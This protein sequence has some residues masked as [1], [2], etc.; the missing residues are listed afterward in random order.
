YV[1]FGIA[2]SW[3]TILGTMVLYLIT[4][5]VGVW[6]LNKPISWGFDITNFVFWVGIGHAGT[7]ISAILYL[8]RQKWRTGINRFADPMTSFTVIFA[9]LISVIHVSRIWVEYLIAPRPNQ[10]NMWPNCRR[11]LLWDFF[12]VG[13]YFT[14]SLCFWYM[15]MIP[16]IATLRDRAKGTIRQIA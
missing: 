13:T 11:P 15:G 14:V 5:G 2:A 8:F 4:T 12:A 10:M 1:A 9:L 7:L 16:D 3:T 6:G